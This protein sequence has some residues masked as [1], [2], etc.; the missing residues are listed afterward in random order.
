MIRQYSFCSLSF[1]EYAFY[2][3]QVEV[4][5]GSFFPMSASGQFVMLHIINFDGHNLIPLPT[6]LAAYTIVITALA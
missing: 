2:F 4:Y 6:S 5:I 1:A 3:V